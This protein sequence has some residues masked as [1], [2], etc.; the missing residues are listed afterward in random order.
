MGSQESGM[1][2]Q[3]SC[4]NSCDR[5]TIDKPIGKRI[6]ESR[7]KQYGNVKSDT[8]YQSLAQPQANTETET[9]T[10]QTPEGRITLADTGDTA[11]FASPDKTKSRNTVHKPYWMANF[12]TAGKFYLKLSTFLTVLP[13]KSRIHMWE[14]SVNLKINGQRKSILNETRERT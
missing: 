13:K 10:A 1:D 9:Q 4:C 6:E 8:K 12:A 3:E 7:R 5:Q 11:T 2:S 14:H